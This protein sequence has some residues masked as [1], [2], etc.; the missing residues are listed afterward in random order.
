MKPIKAGRRLVITYNLGQTNNDI[1]IKA[2]EDMSSKIARYFLWWRQAI[3][4]DT[5]I[6]R[7]L[8]IMLNHGYTGELSFNVI[9]GSDQE[10]LLPFKEACAS[11]GIFLCL[12]NIERA[13]VGHTEPDYE[14]END[15]DPSS[16]SEFHIISDTLES[17]IQLRTVF[18]MSGEPIGHDIDF[19]ESNF[20]D[21]GPFDGCLP[22]EETDYSGRIG[23]DGLAEQIYR[24]TVRKRSP[25]YPTFIVHS[26]T[27]IVIRW[28]FSCPD[29][30]GLH[31]L[32][33]PKASCPSQRQE[34]GSAY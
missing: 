13:I 17:N 20:I 33:T 3:E 2:P 22:D 6:P 1:T 14:S 19:E 26:L 30:T 31:S 8:A 9:N 32:S 10:L 15:D 27:C 5:N 21:P 4:Q 24:R 18:D 7:A 28:L 25:F 29:L 12:A 23:M 16:S 11:T 34:L